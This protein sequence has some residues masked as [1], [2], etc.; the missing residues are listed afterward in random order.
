MRTRRCH[1]S[2]LPAA[3]ARGIVPSPKWARGR[4]ENLRRDMGSCPGAGTPVS[5][6]DRTA[7]R[8]NPFA[9]LLPDSMASG[10]LQPQDDDGSGWTSILITEPRHFLMSAGVSSG[11][12]RTNALN[13]RARCPRPV[14]LGGRV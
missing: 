11:V 9:M 3:D 10:Q 4:L 1:S 13:V 6:I 12:A 8:K 14:P 2:D 5:A 7:S